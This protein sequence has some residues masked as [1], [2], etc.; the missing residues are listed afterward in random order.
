MPTRSAT[1]VG[2]IHQFDLLVKRSVVV[3]QQGTGDV[4]ACGGFEFRDVIPEASV[5]GKQHD[6][7]I[8]GSQ[9]GT[10]GGW[11]SPAQRPGR[12]DERL[13]RVI[14]VDQGS[15]PHAAVAGVG[16]EDGVGGQQPSQVAANPLGTQRN[17]VG[18]QQRPNL[19]SP[20]RS[21][22]GH[23][24]AP[25]LAVDRGRRVGDFEHLV[26]HR[27][28]VAAETGLVGIV[29]TEFFGV[30]VQLHDGG[31]CRRSSPVSRHLAAG[32]TADEEDEVGF[33]QCLVGTLAA[34]VAGDADV[35]KVVG[36][37]RV[38]GV[39]RRGDRDAECFGQLQQL[40]T[41]CRTA[42][43]STSDNHRP[44]GSRQC[45]N[46]RGDILGRCGHPHGRD[47][48][49]GR[50]GRR[51][52][53]QLVEF[54]LTHVPAQLDMSRAGCAAGCVA[55]GLANGLGQPVDRL[56]SRTRLGDRRKQAEVV[57]FLI[58]VSPGGFG[59]GVSGSTGD[60]DDW[61][62]AQVG[63]AESC[64]EIG[65]TDALSQSDAGLAL[66]SSESVGHVDGGFFAVSHHTG[67]AR[68]AEFHFGE[69]LIEDCRDEEDVA[70]LVEAEYVGE[71]LSTGESGHG[72]WI[73]SRLPVQSSCSP[74]A[75][76][77]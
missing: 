75:E 8:G 62:A 57:D 73:P 37:D 36:G 31:V 66:G 68:V 69:S 13:V 60:G 70:D 65:G 53:I 6:R 40:A 55:E 17:T 19:V 20:L 28:G 26:E 39:H 50:V 11:Q 4:P 59:A 42:D 41:G 51:L 7:S 49:V 24:D 54:N 9:L 33:E 43:S 18:F 30:D 67:D 12:S 63:V 45:G 25:G 10:Q 74:A 5:A 14:Q 32:V 72:C 16:D 61:R 48:H 38:L 47:R 58:G 21:K 22:L 56:D 71:V 23:T 15:G 52:D 34:I 27:G 1:A 3:D 76:Q 29:P 35:E 46:R 2:R 64:G 44:G 77:V